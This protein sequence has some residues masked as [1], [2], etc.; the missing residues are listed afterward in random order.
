MHIIIKIRRVGYDTEHVV[1]KIC[2]KRFE[3]FL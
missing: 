1:V 2:V 3:K